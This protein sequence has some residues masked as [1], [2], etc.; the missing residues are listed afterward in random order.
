MSGRNM[1]VCF[2]Q[3]IYWRN[4]NYDL[5]GYCLPLWHEKRKN[6]INLKS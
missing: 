2:K 6:F 4:Y 5:P 1:G 3:T